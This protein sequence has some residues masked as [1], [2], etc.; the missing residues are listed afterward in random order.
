[1][2]SSCPRHH[3]RVEHHDKAGFP[4][5]S[6]L[7]GDGTPWT[8]WSEYRTRFQ[9][10]RQKAVARHLGLFIDFTHARQH[11]FLP[12]ESRGRL[13][14]AFADALVTGTI[15]GGDSTGLWWLP[16]SIREAKL[17]LS[18]VTAFG[19]WLN[20]RGFAPALNPTRSATPEE[21]ILF[22]RRWSQRR[23]V[24]S[25]HISRR[26]RV[27]RSG[28]PGVG[29]LWSV[30]RASPTRT[31]QTHSLTMP[32]LPCSAMASRAE[33][34]RPTGPRCGIRRSPS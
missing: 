33:V 29:K 23:P 10:A 5:I 9:I 15:R 25:S 31:S 17:T 11:D 27:T 34:G 21:T 7:V 12:L 13:M 14:Q 18:D 20:E 26:G 4:V 3:A 16:L 28:P 32:S 22:W 30:P 19:D 24:P 1:M 2:F 8:R 6:M